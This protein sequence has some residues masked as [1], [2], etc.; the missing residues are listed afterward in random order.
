MRYLYSMIVLAAVFAMTSVSGAQISLP[1]VDDFEGY[2]DGA[3]PSPDWSSYYSGNSATVTTSEAYAGSKCFQLSGAS[4]WSRSDVVHVDFPNDFTWTAAVMVAEGSPGGMVGQAKSWGGADATNRAYVSPDDNRI[5]WGIS[6]ERT[7][8]L[9]DHCETGVWYYFV[10]SIHGFHTAASTADIILTHPGGT[11]VRTGLPAD[12]YTKA[13]DPYLQLHTFSRAASTIYVDEVTITGKQAATVPDQLPGDINHDGQVDLD[14][15]VLLKNN[16]GHV[17]Y[18]AVDLGDGVTMT[19]AHI[20]AGTF[21]MGSPETELDRLSNE[22]PRHEVTLTDSFYMGVHEVTQRQY[23]TVMGT[24]P[25]QFTSSGLDAPVEQVSWNDAT[26]FC[27]ALSQFIGKEVMLPTE[28]QWEYACRAGTTTRFH[29]GDDPAYLLC[30]HYAWCDGSSRTHDVGMKLPNGWGLY[31]TGGNVWEWCA[32]WY[33]SAYPSG[34][35][36]NPTGPVS[37][38]YRV[39]RSASWDSPCRAT[40]SASRGGNYPHFSGNNVGFRVVV[41]P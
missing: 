37:G 18:L 8:E 34:S 12:N 36:V 11:V 25:S 24:N 1:F 32:D 3:Y 13:D 21:M 40:R 17:K 7:V 22:G 20:P 14:D 10:V 23:Q 27:A 4:G 19:L 35:A 26:A 41:M 29:Y 2:A 5:S 38:T 39:Y 33:E 31:D 15:F 6:G 28:A 30:E 9:L 16:F